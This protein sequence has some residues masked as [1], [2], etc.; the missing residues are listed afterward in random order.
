[1]KIIAL[2]ETTWEKLKRMREKDFGIIDSIIYATA[3]TLKARL[4][5]GDPHLTMLMRQ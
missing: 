3:L 1:M 5:T 4:V 2:S